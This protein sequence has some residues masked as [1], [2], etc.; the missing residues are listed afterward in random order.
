MTNPPGGVP[1]PCINICRIHPG[2]GW[3]EGCL[4]TLDEITV[5]SRLGDAGKTAVLARV[6]E[7]RVTWIARLAGGADKAVT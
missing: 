6:A 3:C 2:T 7:R 4:R 1:S 5:W